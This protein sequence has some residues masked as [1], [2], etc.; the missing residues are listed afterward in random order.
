MV[1]V[2]VL[3]ALI[4]LAP[5]YGWQLRAWLGRPTAAQDANSTALTA[6]NQALEAQLSVLQGVA[7]QLP[8]VPAGT[9]PAIVYSRYPL[10]FKNEILVNVG[11]NENVTTGTAALFQGVYIG[12]VEKTFPGTS[13]IQTVFDGNFKMPV[14]VGSAGYDELFVGGAAPRV[15]TLAKTAAVRPGD[16]VY[17]AGEGV[18]YGLPIGIVQ[19]TSTSPDNLFQE[20]SLGFAYDMNTVQAVSLV[21]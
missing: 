13:L 18:P 14:R 2:I 12:S 10:N 21:R 3:I 11:A 16:I 15:T 9:V 19:S 17:T 8:S 4:F 7:S 1:C 20:A 6:E 5:Q